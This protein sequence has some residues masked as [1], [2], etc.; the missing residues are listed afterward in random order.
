MYHRYVAG[1]ILGI[2]PSMPDA[3]V[4]I[5]WDVCADV[6]PQYSTYSEYVHSEYRVH[7]ALRVLSV[8]QYWRPKCCE[9]WEYEQC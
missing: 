4:T 3:H 9:Y 7:F 2:L 1:K 6:R 5:F 8:L